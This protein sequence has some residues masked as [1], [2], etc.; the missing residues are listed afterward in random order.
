MPKNMKKKLKTNKI[1]NLILSIKTSIFELLFD[2]ILKP[3]F[4]K[5]HKFKTLIFIK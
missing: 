3:T 4:L 1:K 5:T 2:T